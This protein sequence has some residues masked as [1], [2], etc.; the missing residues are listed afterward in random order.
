MNGKIIVIVAWICA[1]LAAPPAYA[2]VMLNEI[3]VKGSERVELY[4][5]GSGA[6]ALVEGHEVATQRF[7]L[8]CVQFFEQ[9]DQRTVAGGEGLPGGDSTWFAVEGDALLEPEIEI[10]FEELHQ[11]VGVTPVER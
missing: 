9:S 5:S 2:A 1:A 6:V 3:V 7:R 11:V 8:P 4:N 10:G